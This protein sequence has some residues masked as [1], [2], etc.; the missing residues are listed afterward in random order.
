MEAY[1]IEKCTKVVAVNMTEAMYEELDCRA[2]ALSKAKSTYI[3]MILN[4]WF[5]SGNKIVLR[6]E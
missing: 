1:K 5:E 4:S 6:E 2:G 3:K